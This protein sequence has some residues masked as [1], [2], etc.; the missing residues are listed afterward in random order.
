M[1]RSLPPEAGAREYHSHLQGRARSPVSRRIE[2]I[3]H[4]P[5]MM[6]SS[7]PP[8]AGAREYDSDLQRRFTMRV[9]ATEGAE[10]ATSR[11]AF[12]PPHTYLSQSNTSIISLGGMQ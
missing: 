1:G 6:G 8:P 3:I 4:D 2:L 7:L 11:F 12:L 5:R 10:N 9:A